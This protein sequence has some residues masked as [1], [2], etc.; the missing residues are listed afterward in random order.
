ME[1]PSE[2]APPRGRRPPAARAGRRVRL[3][4]RRGPRRRLHARDARARDPSLRATT[5]TAQWTPFEKPFVETWSAGDG[6][7]EIEEHLVPYGFLSQ[8]YAYWRWGLNGALSSSARGPSATS[9]FYP[10][11]AH[12][13]RAVER[14]AI[15][16][17]AV[18][19][20]DVRYAALDTSW[21][22]KRLSRDFGLKPKALNARGAR[23]P[24]L[25]EVAM[26]PTCVYDHTPDLVKR[27]R[28]LR[29][30]LAYDEPLTI[31]VAGDVACRL[32]LPATHHAY[33]LS[34]DA[35]AASC[36]ANG[37]AWFPQGLEGL[38]SYGF[39]A[40]PRDR[41]RAAPRPW[42]PLADRTA[43]LDDG[44]SVNPRKPSRE[45]LVKALRGGQG[46]ALEALAA[47]GGRGL[48]LETSLADGGDVVYGDLGEPGDHD[49][50]IARSVFALCAAGDVWSSGACSALASRDPVVDATYVTDG[51]ESAKGCDDPA[52]FWRDG[53]GGFDRGAPFVFVKDWDNLAEALEGFGAADDAVLETRLA[54]LDAYR[55]ALEDHLRA[56]L[57]ARPPAKTRT[58][59]AA[60]PLSA[61]DERDQL[62]AV[63][64][65]YARDWYGD[66]ADSPAVPGA[67]CGTTLP[68]E[69]EGVDL[70]ML[71]FDAACAPPS[72]AAFECRDA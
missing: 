53:G 50:A 1:A 46:A 3:R 17:H 60:A 58:A 72:V 18:V 45:K 11:A 52:R 19:Y 70:G 57:L 2:A 13:A 5:T 7:V 59:C 56:V 69:M 44:L 61:A 9:H 26:D 47:R 32:K 37:A 27:S 20:V 4:R 65:Y 6:S 25:D 38:P 71:C 62:A 31:V 15:A 14:G 36:A 29:A 8:A 40:G 67:T 64:S 41:R 63:A 49:G 51:G 66:H 10:S 43:L 39:A 55:A 12:L 48:R 24:G 34:G 23:S 33:V 68:T 30:L 28:L 54:D 22:A 21:D 35:G 42:T 16:R